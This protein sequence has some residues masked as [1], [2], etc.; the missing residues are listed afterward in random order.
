MFKTESLIF[1]SFGSPSPK[2]VDC[3]DSDVDT[4]SE[5]RQ[6]FFAVCPTASHVYFFHKKL[7]YGEKKNFSITCTQKL[8]RKKTT[9]KLM[10]FLIIETSNYVNLFI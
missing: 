5:S 1:I 2:E 6:S 3:N 9:G 10:K 8:S 7:N 4:E